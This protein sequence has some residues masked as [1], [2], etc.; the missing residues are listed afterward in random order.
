MLALLRNPVIAAGVLVILGF[1]FVNSAAGSFTAGAL[2]VPEEKGFE[3]KGWKGAVQFVHP[4]G[5]QDFVGSW[6]RDGN[7]EAIT[8][9]GALT[10]TSALHPFDWPKK[11]RYHL[12]VGDS[13]QPFWTS[14]EFDTYVAQNLGQGKTMAVT[15]ANIAVPGPTP[16]DVVLRATLEVAQGRCGCEWRTAAQDGA[17][18]LSGGHELKLEGDTTRFAEGE[19]ATF[20]LKTGAGGPWKV[21]VFRGTGE[22]A[23]GAVSGSLQVAAWGGG[24]TSPSTCRELRFDGEFDGKIK[25]FVPYNAFRADGK[26]EWKLRLTNEVWERHEER[27]FVIDN[28][29]LAPE[30]PDIT[31][32]DPKPAVGETL[33]IKFSAR[34][35]GITKAPITHF[36]VSAW[37]GG[38]GGMPAGGENVILDS[39][40]VDA[41]LDGDH[42]TGTVSIQITKAV[43]IQ[44]QPNSVDQQGRPSGSRISSAQVDELVQGGLPD[45]TDNGE[46]FVLPEGADLNFGGF[47]PP[48]PRDNTELLILI[49]LATL[50]IAGAAFYFLPAPI[51]LRV[52]AV[53]LVAVIGF[54]LAFGVT[55]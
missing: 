37:Y 44:I 32:S 49:A 20:R 25:F 5:G 22:K 7:S 14:E 40:R 39:R 19:T 54:G 52:A 3:T 23:C 8:L 15:A 43:P 6:D 4:R 38:S 10:D 35:N 16:R 55:T 33:T 9:R 47:Y 13:A 41:R 51:H 36:T 21:E 17:R 34:A 24:W 2:I 18:L 1:A 31:L 53:G 27:L 26:N 12:Y 29:R 50:A 46:T 42:Y 28:S 30:V 11:A 45:P 48:S